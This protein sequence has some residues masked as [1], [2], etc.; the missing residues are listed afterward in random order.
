[1]AAWIGWSAQP[2]YYE[3]C[4][5]DGYVCSGGAQ[6]ASVE[7]Y[8]DEATTIADAGQQPTDATDWMPL[9]VFAIVPSEDA[10]MDVLLQLA[11]SKEGTI[12][13]T[14]VNGPANVMLPLLGSVD[15]SSQRAAWKVGEEEAIVMETMLESLTKDQ[16]TIL[17]HFDGGVTESWWMFRIDEQ[18][19]REIQSTVGANQSRAQLA[20]AFDKLLPSLNDSWKKYLA[21]PDEVFS[22]SEVTD[23]DAL[24][25]ALTHYDRVAGDSSYAQIAAY[26]GFPETREA[27]KGL[28]DDLTSASESAP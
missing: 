5:Q 8:T 16:S 12:A 20:E 11:I 24:R 13:G 4:V 22:G 2:V 6:I 21:L 1:L 28:L 10:P 27:L 23:V 17:L 3:Y 7:Q 15:S 9:G 25:K 14:F 26:P 18:T 19:A